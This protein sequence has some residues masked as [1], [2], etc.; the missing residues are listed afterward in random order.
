MLQVNARVDPSPDVGVIVTLRDV[1]SPVA[2]ASISQKKSF[3]APMTISTAEASL[4][5]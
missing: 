1:F 5:K 4:V 3:A 2:Q